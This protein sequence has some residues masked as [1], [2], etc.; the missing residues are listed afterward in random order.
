MAV[1]P[2]PIPPPT[3]TSSRPGQLREDRDHHKSN[4][5]IF[6]THVLF[7]L[8]RRGTHT[9]VFPDSG[10]RKYAVNQEIRY[11]RSMYERPDK[12]TCKQTAKISKTEER[13]RC[14]LD[15]KCHSIIF[16]TNGVVINRVGFVTPA[17]SIVRIFFVLEKLALRQ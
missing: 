5:K 7:V 16:R 17:L 3:V 4:G 10:A 8:E 2:K 1:S 13:K 14:P 11:V 12:R 9:I 6:N 15:G